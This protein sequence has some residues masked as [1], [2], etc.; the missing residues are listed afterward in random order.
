VSSVQG[1]RSRAQGT[2]PDQ[3]TL[4][5]SVVM[6]C[7]DEAETVGQCV[8]IALGELERLELGGEV[9]VVDNGSTDDG[10]ALAEAAGANVVSEPRRG[11]GRAYLAGLARARGRH[12]VM[13]DADLSYDFCE[14]DRFLTELDRGADLVVGNRMGAI[15]PGAMP[16]S[17]RWIGNPLT[18]GAVRM[19][20]RPG[21]GDAWCGLRAL[22]REALEA[23]ELRGTGMEF[24]LEMVV[25]AKQAGLNIRELP[26]ALRPRGGESKLLRYRDGWR[27]VRYL[28][29]A[30]RGRLR[31]PADAPEY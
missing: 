29:S 5:V 10:G 26:I 16:W 8:S 30:R 22:R 1:M 9:V 11:Y 24:A 14:I 28:M 3:T 31:E 13:G 20:F 27:G 12:I 15:H 18:S 17:H 19:L 2:A 4:D 25:R 6:P 21:I 7:L 23:L